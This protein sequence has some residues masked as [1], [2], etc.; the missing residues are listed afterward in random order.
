VIT[1]DRTHPFHYF[2]LHLDTLK[3]ARRTLWVQP[4]VIRLELLK[5]LYG[6]ARIVED[7]KHL[8]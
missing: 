7:D 1:V 3:G 4:D 5:N 8:G 2:L 6:V